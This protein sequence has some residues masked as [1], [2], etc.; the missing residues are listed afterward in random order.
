M[1]TVYSLI[2]WGGK[3]GK[4]VTV[5]SSTDWV[6]LTRHG[7]KNGKGVQF[8][9][10]TLPT[11]AGTALALN[12]TYY[13]K[14]ISTSTCE[15]YYDAAL[16][17]KI[18][19]TSTGS[20]LVLKGSYYQ[21]LSDKSRWTYSGNE[22][23]FDGINS[24]N[25]ARAG[26]DQWD[27]EVA[28]IGEFFEEDT[29]DATISIT[30][31]ALFVL[32]TTLVNGVRSSAWHKDVSGGYVL[33]RTTIYAGYIVSLKNYRCEV[34]GFTLKANGTGGVSAI[35][36]KAN[37]GCRNMRLL[38][39]NKTGTGVTLQATGAYAFYNH[40]EGFQYGCQANYALAATVFAN[41]TV[42][43]NATG[44]YAGSTVNGFWYNNICA[45]NTTANWGANSSGIEGASSN[46][47]E[48][49]DANLPWMTSG[50]TRLVVDQSNFVNFA[51]SD[52]RPAPPLH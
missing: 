15:L 48:T 32:V 50:G 25:T 6:T 44:V 4:A 28:E 3:D 31:P 5:S 29:A 23:I 11:V 47:G 43:K 45:G 9:S 22:Y 36:C 37:S 19:F 18:N 34:D 40:I 51:G 17:N 13:A 10:G 21:G 24:W 39:Y 38:G 46:S 1:A 14:R 27:T 52:Y 42:V 30:V 33:S 26:A 8:A 16:T 41:N 35:A 20:S 7:L 49:G 2:C 12:T